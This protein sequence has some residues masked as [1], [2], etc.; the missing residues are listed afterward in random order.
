MVFQ[1]SIFRCGNA[2]RSCETRGF[3]VYTALQKEGSHHSPK[4]RMS[5]HLTN[6]FNMPRSLLLLFSN[7]PREL[8]CHP[9]KGP[10]QKETSDQHHETERSEDA[11]GVSRT[12]LTSFFKKVCPK[13]RRDGDGYHGQ[14]TYPPSNVPPS[15]RAGLMIRAYE[16]HWF[17]LIRPAIKPLFLGG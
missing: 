1:A 5:L 12:T 9:K 2:G 14:S 7:T 17:P 15:A 3:L 6:G 10:F 8:A 11:R 16:N 4:K 13:V